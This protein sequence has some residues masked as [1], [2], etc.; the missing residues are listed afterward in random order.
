VPFR[1]L[2]GFDR[3]GNVGV[4]EQR[5]LQIVVPRT[6]FY[7][8]NNTGDKVYYLFSPLHF[9]ISFL[10]LPSPLTF[11]HRFCILE[12]ITWMSQTQSLLYPL[13]D[14]STHP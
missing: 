11:S 13:F 9:S 4:N 3:V 6:S 5:Q 14:P 7:L 1:A 12:H 2:V 10:P 8:T